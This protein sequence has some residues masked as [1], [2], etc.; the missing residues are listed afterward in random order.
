MTPETGP[1]T[2]PVRVLVL[3]GPNLDLLGTREPE[4]YGT[5]TLAQLTARLDARAAALGLELRHVQSNHE[6]ALVDAVRDA[7]AA[8]LR[9]AVVNAAA[10]THTSVALRDV[11]LATRLPFVEVHLTNPWAREPFRRRNLLVDL[12]R[13]TVSG[14]GAAGYELALDGLAAQLTR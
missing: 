1:G 6:G 7:A 11:F 5:V 12:S 4:R 9:G 14:F 2:G 3:Q 8:G 10:Y 13:G